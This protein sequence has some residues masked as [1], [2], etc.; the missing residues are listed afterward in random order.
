MPA[1]PA[2]A[3]N[4]AHPRHQLTDEDKADRLATAAGFRLALLPIKGRDQAKLV[5]LVTKYGCP[6][7][8]N[9]LAGL[10]AEAD[11]P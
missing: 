2:G 5:D 1:Q 11:R 6:A 3:R 8:L 10:I 4:S 7:V 9:T